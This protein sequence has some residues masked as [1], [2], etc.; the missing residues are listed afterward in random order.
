MGGEE[1]KFA[2]TVFLLDE[3]HVHTHMQLLHVD[4]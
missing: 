2:V 4:T 1:W 3:V